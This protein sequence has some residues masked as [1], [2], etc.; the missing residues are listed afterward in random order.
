M[1]RKCQHKQSFHP[2]LAISRLLTSLIGYK[3][4]WLTTRSICSVLIRYFD[5]RHISSV[6][7]QQD[8]ALIFGTNT[9]ERRGVCGLE[10]NSGVMRAAKG[11][12]GIDILEAAGVVDILDGIAEVTGSIA[13]VCFR[14]MPACCDGEHQ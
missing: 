8:I 14:P 1:I 11:A 4:T 10:V 9:R 5:T 6:S 13:R 2:L 3:L 7:I 12:T